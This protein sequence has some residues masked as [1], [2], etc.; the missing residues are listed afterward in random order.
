MV[1]FTRTHALVLVA[2][3]VVLVL[4][5]VGCWW[6]ASSAAAVA[7]EA[8]VGAPR[9][10]GRPTAC[11][12]HKVFAPTEDDDED[13]LLRLYVI[14]RTTGNV[15]V[16]GPKPEQYTERVTKAEHKHSYE[17]AV[18][19]CMRTPR[20]VGFVLAAPSDAAPEAPGTTGAG[21]QRYTALFFEAGDAEEMRDITRATYDDPA[22]RVRLTQHVF[23]LYPRVDK[24]AEP[25]FCVHPM[26]VREKLDVMGLRVHT[27]KTTEPAKN[28]RT[29]KRYCT[30]L[31]LAGFSCKR[32]A[33]DEIAFYK[34]V[35]ESASK[36]DMN[37]RLMEATDSLEAEDVDGDR[38][39][40][41]L[42]DSACRTTVAD[43]DSVVQW[44]EWWKNR[45]LGT[46]VRI[47]PMLAERDVQR[48]TCV[49]TA[50]YNC[51]LNESDT[52]SAQAYVK[53]HQGDDAA[54][55]LA[56]AGPEGVDNDAYKIYKDANNKLFFRQRDR[57]CENRIGHPGTIPEGASD[58]V[59]ELVSAGC[60]TDLF[61]NS[62]FFNSMCDRV[63]KDRVGEDTPVYRR[64]LGRCVP[65]KH[66]HIPNRTVCNV[67]SLRAKFGNEGGEGQCSTMCGIPSLD[68]DR[69]YQ[70]LFHHPK[71]KG[72]GGEAL[73]T[74][75]THKRK[76]LSECQAL[77]DASPE[78]CD[79]FTISPCSTSA[80][81]CMGTC[82]LK[83]RAQPADGA[84]GEPQPPLQVSGTR[85]APTKRIYMKQA[86]Y[87]ASDPHLKGVYERNNYCRM[88]GQPYYNYQFGGDYADVFSSRHQ[89]HNIQASGNVMQLQQAPVEYFENAP[90]NEVSGMDPMTKALTLEGGDIDV[91]SIQMAAGQLVSNNKAYR[92]QFLAPP[93]IVE[94]SVAGD[95]VLAF[96]GAPPSTYLK[97]VR[98]TLADHLDVDAQQLELNV[99]P[100]PSPST[101]PSVVQF[102]VIVYRDDIMEE[103]VDAGAS[104]EEV[105]LTQGLKN[106]AQLSQALRKAFAGSLK[107]AS[108]EVSESDT[109]TPMEESAASPL[110][111]Q[112]VGRITLAKPVN[113]AAVKKTDAEFAYIRETFILAVQKTLQRIAALSPSQ[114]NL[115]E[116]KLNTAN[117]GESQ[118]SFNMNVGI[119]PS[120]VEDV[121]TLLYSKLD[122]VQSSILKTC[123]L[124]LGDAS[125]WTNITL[126]PLYL[127]LLSDS[128][129][130]G[131]IFQ[132]FLDMKDVVQLTGTSVRLLP[133]KTIPHPPWVIAR[134]PI[135]T[136]SA[137]TPYGMTIRAH[138]GEQSRVVVLTRINEAD[139]Q[140]EMELS[141]T[142]A[143]G[144]GHAT[145]DDNTAD[146]AFRLT[147]NAD[148]VRIYH[149]QST[150]VLSKS[151]RTFEEGTAIQFIVVCVLTDNTD[152]V[153]F[154]A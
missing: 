89:L 120:D 137:G 118:I 26:L 65:E 133:D 40:Y 49:D 7:S 117:N 106:D 16:A 130:N 143:M 57:C 87:D 51:F 148:G 60:N 121:I 134:R 132:Y 50:D 3:L 122:T 113:A 154:G 67:A 145:I 153:D 100:S 52:A 131:V 92:F 141:G 152:R 119:R 61:A 135:V 20:F 6:R 62:T 21:L 147:A 83:R 149:D 48:R 4:I 32:D 39:F 30:R 56:L 28:V 41:R 23:K 104:A 45:E 37:A 125:S 110:K 31:G 108:A 27:P 59:H 71:S 91:S 18:I 64:D 112:L 46:G 53:E 75:G 146:K 33:Q 115:N 127:H 84:P 150:A 63:C 139:T 129:D 140:F 81:K 43:R 25:S 58:I 123:T 69:G 86:S 5:G 138:L 109:E 116:F 151:A 90:A 88:D 54:K 107:S 8:F 111:I 136:L 66:K 99:Q 94:G 47:H 96:K 34:Y 105:R 35:D 70:R 101:F 142:R 36:R 29:A 74:V 78:G 114:L 124:R 128:Q 24:C 103:E 14:D 38:V 85:V 44:R 79:L 1:S 144:N 19:A 98:T 72:E 42:S 11:R 10:N 126:S 55:A 15:H 80:D 82:T 97:T 9:F 12:L 68:Q 73:E 95:L 93:P 102:R 77:C 2:V 76:A 13:P 17:E 22:Q